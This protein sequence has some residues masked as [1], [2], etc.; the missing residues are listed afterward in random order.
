MQ[1]NGPSPAPPPMQSG[2]NNPYDFLYQQPPKKSFF[3]GGDQKQRI[4][5]VAGGGVALLLLV[6][7]LFSVLFGGSNNGD[8][9]LRV[10]QKQSELIRI[11]DIAVQK[12]RTSTAKNL[13]IT[14]S[15]SITSEQKS[16]T[17]VMS[18]KPKPQQLA[19][20]K[21]AQTDILLTEAEQNNRFDEVYVTEIEK[22]LEEYQKLVKVAYDGA[23]SKRVRDVL[24]A[25]YRNASVLAGV[26]EE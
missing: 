6:V 25:E 2:G 5:I 16:L 23:S 13:A 4:L 7:M 10:A 9:L 21:N 24:E 3:G 12:S 18:P 19:L 22:Q 26:Q 1:P 8:Q 20:G 14:T 15:M 11:S 17:Q